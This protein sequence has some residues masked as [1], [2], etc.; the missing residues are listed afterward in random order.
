[1]KDDLLEVSYHDQALFLNRVKPVGLEERWLDGLLVNSVEEQD[2][3]LFTSCRT[4]V[5]KLYFN[6]HAR[7]IFLVVHVTH[8]RIRVRIVKALNRL[9]GRLTAAWLFDCVRKS[10]SATST[11]ERTREFQADSAIPLRSQLPLLS[12][13]AFLT[14][15]LRPFWK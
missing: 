9:P 3:H 7:Q 1:M 12:L 13:S 10:T 15:S 14:L 8:T 6:R 2:F 4:S 11:E 5:S